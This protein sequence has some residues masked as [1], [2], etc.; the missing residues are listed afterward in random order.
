MNRQIT[1][2]SLLK[3][4]KTHLFV[5]HMQLFLSFFAKKKKFFCNLALFN[6]SLFD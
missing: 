5:C 4:E 2:S 1:H 3:K 6:K